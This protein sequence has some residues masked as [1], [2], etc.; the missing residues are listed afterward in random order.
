MYVYKSSS[1]YFLDVSKK[2]KG[3][4]LYVKMPFFF[5]F[6]F[7]FRAVPVAYGSSQARG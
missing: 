5:F 1:V 3:L 6:F 7:L 4:G 2:G